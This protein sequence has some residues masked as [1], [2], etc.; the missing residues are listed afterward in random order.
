MNDYNRSPELGTTFVEVDVG[1][2]IRLWIQD[3][4]IPPA[5]TEVES[6]RSRLQLLLLNRCKCPLCSPQSHR[7]RLFIP[8]SIQRKVRTYFTI[9][10]Q[11]S[12]DQLSVM[13]TMKRASISCSFSQSL[14]NKSCIII[15]IIITSHRYL[16]CDFFNESRR[17]KVPKPYSKE[18]MS[19]GTF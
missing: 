10:R 17:T 19:S 12:T 11:T 14:T 3:R 9:S 1:C 5:V 13:P 15:I 18:S 4:G 6:H 8:I 16:F 2:C 7:E